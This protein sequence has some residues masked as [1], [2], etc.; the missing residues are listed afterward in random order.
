MDI[1]SLKLPPELHRRVKNAAAERG[2]NRSELFRLA[3]EH[4]L[5]AGRDSFP[6]SVADAARDLAGC[7]SGARDLST[8]AA[9]MKDYGA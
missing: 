8:G 3:L 1:V 5:D 9:H 2:V 4:Y 7:F 6:A